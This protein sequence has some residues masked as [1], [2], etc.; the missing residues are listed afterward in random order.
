MGL[1][2]KQAKGYGGFVAP[3]ILTDDPALHLGPY[4]SKFEKNKRWFIV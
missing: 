4:N 1:Y 2:C 3:R